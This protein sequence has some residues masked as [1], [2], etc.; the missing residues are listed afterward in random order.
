MITALDPSPGRP[1]LLFY[2]DEA[3][4][5]IPAGAGKPLA[6]PALIRLFAQGRKYGVASLI[7]TQSPRSVDYNVFGNCSTKLVG[8]LESQQDLQ[9]V[10]QWFATDGPTPPWIAARKGA[11]AGSFVGRW[12]QILPTLEGRAFRSRP[13]FSLHEGAWSPDRLEREMR[14]GFEQSQDSRVAGA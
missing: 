6:K 14:S 10:A 4:D 13:L 5:Y 2:L 12:P 3:R 8:R 11:E 9:R 1:N 7:C